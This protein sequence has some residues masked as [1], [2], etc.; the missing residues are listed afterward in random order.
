MTDVW[1]DSV[2]GFL[3]GGLVLS[4]VWGLLWLTISII[5]LSRGTC[6]WRIVL[7]SSVG[8]GVPLILAMALVWWMGGLEHVTP[9]FAV[10]L[11]GM[12]MV[13][14]GFWLRRMPDGRRAGAHLAS[15]VRHLMED[16]LG[17]HEGCG[18]CHGGDDQRSCR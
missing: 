7:M 12:P 11:M 5:G 2:V 14:L 4:A 13:V 8:G 10:G 3:T 15:A 1:I 17:K 9:V 16:L 6:G 18:G